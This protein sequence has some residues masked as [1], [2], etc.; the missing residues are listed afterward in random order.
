MTSDNTIFSNMSGAGSAAM[1]EV[2]VSLQ[3]QKVEV[4]ALLTQKQQ[5]LTQAD[6]DRQNCRRTT[7]GVVTWNNGCL[8]ANTILKNNLSTDIADLQQRLID[9]DAQIQKA[10]SDYQAAVAAESAATQAQAAAQ[11]QVLQAQAMANPETARVTLEA[12]TAQKQA[13]IDAEQEQ[14][15]IYAGAGI[16][17]LIILAVAAMFILKK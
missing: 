17:V 3:N 16:M 5:E 9:L 10:Q 2:L 11:V 7:W 13:A 4:N 1:Q 8:D 12:Q 6:V 15:M 14:T